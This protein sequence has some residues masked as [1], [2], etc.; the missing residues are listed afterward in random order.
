MK[1]YCGKNRKGVWKASLDESK[2]RKFDDIFES[3]IET[4]H[5]DKVYMIQ[6]YYGYD[7]NWSLGDMYDVIKTI[8]KAFYSV[9]TAKKY[10]VWKER[11][12]NA[13]RNPK[14]FHVSPFSIASDNYGD[15]FLFGDVMEDKFNMKIIGVKVI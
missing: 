6:T 3:E 7:Y 10:T 2:I 13:K 11:E 14:N 9:S 15:P 8:P 12:E 5:N 4:I 1:I